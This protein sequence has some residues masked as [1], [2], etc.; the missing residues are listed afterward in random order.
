VVLPKADTPVISP[1]EGSFT[2]RQQVTI[3]DGTANASIYYSRDGTSTEANCYAY[4]G[5][6][7][8]T[9]S[10]TLS[11]IAMVPEHKPALWRRP[12]SSC[13]RPLQSSS[14]P[15]ERKTTSLSS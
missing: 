14:C 5:P 1:A 4:T 12:Y 7:A 3:D 2:S 11:A 9:V 15:R 10:L 13:R 6:I 8:V